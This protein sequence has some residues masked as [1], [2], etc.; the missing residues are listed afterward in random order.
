MPPVKDDKPTS[1]RK[2][3]TSAVPVASQSKTSSSTV[4][5]QS[6]RA[7][8][9]TASS[10]SKNTSASGSAIGC[11]SKTTLVDRR[12]SHKS[13]KTEGSAAA[14]STSVCS[15]Q[16]R[17]SSVAGTSKSHAVDRTLPHSLSGSAIAASCTSS[18]KALPEASSQTLSASTG[19]GKLP[20][21]STGGIR[22][23]GQVLKP[24][25]IGQGG[26]KLTRAESQR[27][28][29]DTSTASSHN[30]R[31]PVAQRVAQA[32][33]SRLTAKKVV[34]K[35][36]LDS[37]NAKRTSVELDRKSNDG[38]E[39]STVELLGDAEAVTPSD[40]LQ[41]CISGD[42]DSGTS[43]V[44][45]ASSDVT[46]TCVD[47]ERKESLSVE[48]PCAVRREQFADQDGSCC[49]LKETPSVELSSSTDMVISSEQ[50]GA[51]RAR[52]L[53]VSSCVSMQSDTG[54][55]TPLCDDEFSL[56]ACN[57]EEDGESVIVNS[58]R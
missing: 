35:C 41:E 18:H 8:P 31:G 26:V 38:S 24:S 19:G 47:G 58:T 36:T 42:V 30:L 27:E 21:V 20:R 14:V 44:V 34:K 16:A 37:C 11:T 32:S 43:S 51:N 3:A 22:N 13:D 48:S 17:R 2:S 57:A 53:S 23:S 5:G 12:P 39:A 7:H 52:C 6:V 15:S 25:G 54:Y 1:V 29:A 46:A 4:K 33:V 55:H 49:N 40:E 50:F 56:D 9:V 10:G 45:G 28:K